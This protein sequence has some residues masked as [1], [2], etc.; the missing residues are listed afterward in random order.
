MWGN[1]SHPTA[2]SVPDSVKTLLLKGI[3]DVRTHEHC[4]WARHRMSDG[5]SEVTI[6]SWE[7]C[8]HALL[9]A[10]AHA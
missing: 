4:L 7:D 9:R 6:A 10:H 8:M 5:Q 1:A 2:E 3:W